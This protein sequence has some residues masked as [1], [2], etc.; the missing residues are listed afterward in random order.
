MA[1]WT[2]DQVAQW[3]IENG[4]EK[5]VQTFR[6]NR[7]ESF[8][9]HRNA[10]FLDEDIDGLALIGL[11]ENEAFQLLTLTNDKGIRRHPSRQLQQEFRRKVD[12]WRKSSDGERISRHPPDRSDPTGS[13]GRSKTLIIKSSD[14]KLK[15]FQSDL[16]FAHLTKHFAKEFQVQLTLPSII[17]PEMKREFAV[18]LIG[19]KEHLS[20]EFER[21]QSVF[22][23]VKEHIFNDDHL[24]KKSK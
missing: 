20:T 15:F 14:P 12:E 1:D 18:E 24:D 22:S 11:R 3:L 16:I 7:D 2:T 9:P 21:I 23:S 13:F 5:Y 4:F 19:K 6:S 10:R 8:S 17:H